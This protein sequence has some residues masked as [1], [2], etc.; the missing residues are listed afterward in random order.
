MIAL[1]TTFLTYLWH[2]VVARLL[3]D[4]LVRPLAIGGALIALLTL[5]VR[6]RGRAR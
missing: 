2:Y 5:L 1:A 4:A 6:F 3:Y